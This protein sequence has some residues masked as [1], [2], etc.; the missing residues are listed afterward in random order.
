[1]T[2]GGVGVRLSVGIMHSSSALLLLLLFIPSR[3]LAEVAGDDDAA[4]VADAGEQRL[5][6]QPRIIIII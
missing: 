3:R 6:L 2:I 5:H 1:M 4:A